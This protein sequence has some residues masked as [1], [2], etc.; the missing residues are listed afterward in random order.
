MFK[1]F[2]FMINVTLNCVMWLSSLE[3]PKHA[4]LSMHD[5]REYYGTQIIKLFNCNLVSFINWLWESLGATE[6]SKGSERIM[7]LNYQKKLRGKLLGRER[8]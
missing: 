6:V 5:D 8:I 3:D 4:W 2:F 7:F 1:E